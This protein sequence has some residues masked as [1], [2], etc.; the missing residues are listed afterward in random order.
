[1]TV[2]N[3]VKFS[4]S[5]VSHNFSILSGLGI[6]PL[7]V[8]STTMCPFS[9]AALAILPMFDAP[10]NTGRPALCAVNGGG[11][12]RSKEGCVY[13]LTQNF[14]FNSVSNVRTIC[15]SSS[16]LRGGGSQPEPFRQRPRTWRGG[17]RTWR[18]GPR[19]PG[20]E[21]AHCVL[22]LLEVNSSFS[23]T[24]LLAYKGKASTC[25]EDKRVKR[26][27]GSHYRCICCRKEWGECQFKRQQK[28]CFFSYSCSNQDLEM[29]PQIVC[30]V[31]LH[32]AI[33]IFMVRNSSLM[34]LEIVHI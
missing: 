27:K 14:S 2:S 23:Q 20:H 17:P 8:R 30:C 15:V 29:A 3:S 22:L 21:G 33:C 34:T 19:R 16:L 9:A 25:Q 13:R 12:L 4:F 6:Q 32:D 7:L 26:R 5:S 1:M 28:V 31:E 24:V 10:I 11:T 18:G